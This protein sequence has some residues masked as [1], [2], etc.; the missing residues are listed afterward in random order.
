MRT[1]GQA[2]VGMRGVAIVAVLSA[3]AIGCSPSQPTSSPSVASPATAPSATE[4][5]T[6]SATPSVGD[7]VLATLRDRQFAA[8][9]TIHGTETVPSSVFIT[10]DSGQPISQPSLEPMVLEWEGEAYVSGTDYLIR[11]EVPDQASL[12]IEEFGIGNDVRRRTFSH[13]WQL[14]STSADPDPKLFGLLAG[15][16]RLEPVGEPAGDTV[17]FRT[18]PTTPLSLVS[19]FM[20]EETAKEPDSGTIEIEAQPDG[21]PVRVLVT[22]SS[23]DLDYSEVLPDPSMTVP[24]RIYEFEYEYDVVD[25]LALPDFVVSSPMSELHSKTGVDLHYSADWTADTSDDSYDEI[26]GFDVVIRVFDFPVPDDAGTEEQERLDA[27]AIWVASDLGYGPPET[28]EM[29]TVA[30]RPAYLMAW[31]SDTGDDPF[32]HLETVFLEGDEIHVIAWHA[33][34]LGTELVERYE[35]ERLLESVKLSSG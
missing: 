16:D 9:V 21:T 30:D 25:R 3:F 18:P 17:R 13:P 33:F 26:D 19:L 20:Q 2:W 8:R 4:A 27:S 11:L 35:F 22:L 14:L 12:V 32:F 1:R 5:S 29:T 31:R 28:I 6:P 34:K 24:P 23:D 15:V 7:A 10:D